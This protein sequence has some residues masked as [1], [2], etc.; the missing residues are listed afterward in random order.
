M[1]VPVFIISFNRLQVGEVVQSSRL[2]VAEEDLIDPEQSRISGGRDHRRRRG[3]RRRG[4]RHRSRHVTR[5]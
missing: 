1:K 4:C 2:I 3:T 5:R